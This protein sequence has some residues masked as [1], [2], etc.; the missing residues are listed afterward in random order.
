MYDTERQEYLE[1]YGVKGMKWG[2]RKQ[3]KAMA[4]S[5]IQRKKNQISK[6]FNKAA[7]SSDPAKR[8][9]GIKKVNALGKELRNDKN[10]SLASKTTT[11]EKAVH[12]FLFGPAAIGTI[13]LHSLARRRGTASA[14]RFAETVDLRDLPKNRD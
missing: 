9:A 12:I 13:P 5:N 11:G 7:A 2:V 4:R 3:K 6:E 1:H 8:A 10:I 14:A